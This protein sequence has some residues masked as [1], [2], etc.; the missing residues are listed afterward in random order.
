[1]SFPMRSTNYLA[2]TNILGELAR[3]EPH[4]GVLAWAE[5]VE[6]LGLSVVTLEEVFFGFAWKPNLRVRNWFQSFVEQQC[7]VFPVTPQIA[8]RGGEIRGSLRSEGQTRSQADM[9]IAAT[10]DLH[11]LTLVTRNTRDFA[12]CRISLLDPFQ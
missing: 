9:L 5:T 2:D 1:M 3:R 4:P 6:T 12:G 11:Q 10:A 8:Q 7:A